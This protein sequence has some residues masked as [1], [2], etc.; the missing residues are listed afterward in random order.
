MTTLLAP[1]PF[2]GTPFKAPFGAGHPKAAPPLSSP[3]I[4]AAMGTNFV[5]QILQV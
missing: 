2:K 1:P 3:V 4:G 5:I